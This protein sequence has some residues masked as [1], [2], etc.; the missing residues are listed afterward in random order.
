MPRGSLVRFE[1]LAGWL[2]VL[3]LAVA[4]LMVGKPSFSNAS[5]PVRGVEDPV[6]A[7][8]AARSITDIDYVLGIAPSPD[9]EVMRIKE[10]LGFLFIGAYT[11]LFLTLALL[12]LRVEGSGRIAGP[13][14]MICALATAAFNVFGNLAVLRILDVPLYRTTAPMIGAIRSASFATWALAALTLGLL[15]TFFFRSPRFIMRSVGGLFLI[16]AAMQLYGLHDNRFLVWEGGPAGLALLGVAIAMLFR[17]PRAT[18][19]LALF[20]LM[21]GVNLHAEVNQVRSYHTHEPSDRTVHF[22]MAVTP[23]QDVLSLVP[24]RN[25]KW[26]LTRVRNWLDKSP[27]DQTI[28][29]PGIS[30]PEKSGSSPGSLVGL[31]IELLV[32]SDGSFAVTV[33]TG[34]YW[35]TSKGKDGTIDNVVSVVDLRTLQILTTIHQDGSSGHYVDR[36]GRLVLEKSMVEGN[37]PTVPNQSRRRGVSLRFFTLP[38]LA[39]DGVCRFTETLEGRTWAPHDQDCGPGLQ[40][41]LDGLTPTRSSFFP[42]GSPCRSAGVS[43]DGQ[44]RWENCETDGRSFFWENPTVTDRHVNI[45]SAKSAAQIGVVKETTR[46][47]VDSRFAEH[48]GRDYLLVMEGGTQLKIYEITEPRP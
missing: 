4:A 28:D 29:V 14:A 15:S 27:A 24:K 9:R 38:G 22:A 40:E 3:C 21:G 2:A 33:A 36:M 30:V 26:R 31:N 34:N 25:G 35:A 19:H 16:T 7:I 1:R 47:S 5:L 45:F 32:T 6:I 12:L 20:L 42:A 44:F 48:D 18:P 37:S 43:R 41:L 39:A 23:T 13:A 8:Q 17:R 11:A 46:D 10:R